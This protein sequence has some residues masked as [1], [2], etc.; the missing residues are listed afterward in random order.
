MA[1][2]RDHPPILPTGGLNTKDPSDVISPNEGVVY[3]NCDTYGNSL[4][5]RAGM[6]RKN[7]TALPKASLVTDRYHNVTISTTSR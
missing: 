2:W 7:M 6:L 1:T 5:K 3:R 4:E